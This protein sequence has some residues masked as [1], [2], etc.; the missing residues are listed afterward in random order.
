MAIKEAY[1]TKELATL[2]DMKVSSS[3]VRRA[4]REQWQSRPRKGR[5]GEVFPHA[6]FSP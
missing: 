4:Q 2:L 5:G 3:V 6:P 1:T